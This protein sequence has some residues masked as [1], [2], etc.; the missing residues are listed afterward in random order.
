MSNYDFL[1]LNDSMSEKQ[2][3]S[4]LICEMEKM[5]TIED[6]EELIKAWENNKNSQK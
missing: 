3:I 1:Y 4:V 5:Q 6:K 2:A